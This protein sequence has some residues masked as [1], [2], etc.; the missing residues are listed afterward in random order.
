MMNVKA[1]GM[2]IATVAAYAMAGLV[3]LP[4]SLQAGDVFS[5]AKSWHRGFVDA[6]GD[7]VLDI[8][9]GKMEFPESLLIADTANAAHV[10]CSSA[11]GGTTWPTQIYNGHTSVVLRTE[12]VV[13][14][15]TKT[16]QSET[17]AYF[18]QDVDFSTSKYYAGAVNFTSPFAVDLTKECTF[19]IRYKWS[20]ESPAGADMQN[21][22]LCAGD[23]A[24]YGFLVS[25]MSNGCYN[26]YSAS[27]YGKT[28]NGATDVRVKPNEWTDFAVTVKNRKMT[29]YSYQ[30]SSD[31]IAILEVNGSS[32]APTGS[33][34]SRVVLGCSYADGGCGYGYNSTAQRIRAFRGSIQ[35]F[36]SWS[37]ALS[38]DEVRQVFAWP[39]TDLVRLGTANDSAQEFEGGVAPTTVNFNVAAKDAGLPQV[40][41]VT[42]TS[43]SAA[44]L[45]NVSVNGAAVG[46][47]SV[48]PGTTATL[49]VKKNLTVAGA[50]TLTLMRTPADPVTIDAIALGGSLQIGN[51]DGSLDEFAPET[52]GGKVFSDVKS[53][54]RGAIPWHGDNYPLRPDVGMNSSQPDF[55]ESLVGDKTSNMHAAAF[56]SPLEGADRSFGSTG[57]SGTHSGILVRTENVVYP[58]ARRTESAK[59]LYFPQ[60]S[61]AQSNGNYTYWTAGLHLNTNNVPFIPK[62]DQVNDSCTFFLRFR[63]DG[64]MPIPGQPAYFMGVGDTLGLT[65]GA[66]IGITE[67]GHYYFYSYRPNLNKTWNGTG[68]IVV[69]PNKWTDFAITLSN[70]KVTIYSYQEGSSSIAVMSATAAGASPSSC[71]ASKN[72]F[73]IGHGR[74]GLV[75]GTWTKNEARAYGFRGSIHSFAAWDRALGEDE[76]RQVFAWPGDSTL[77]NFGV[78]NDSNAEFGDTDQR[79]TAGMTVNNYSNGNDFWFS[80]RAVFTDAHSAQQ[81]NLR[82]LS[83]ANAD[84]SYILCMM[85]TADSDDSSFSLTINGSSV[86]TFTVTHGAMAYL[87]IPRGFLRETTGTDQNT[88]KLTRT[89]SGA[90]VKLDAFLVRRASSGDY[91]ATDLDQSDCAFGRYELVNGSEV[92]QP[93]SIHVDVPDAIAGNADYSVRVVV[94]FKASEAQTLTLAANGAAVAT[95]NAA[96]SDEIQKFKADVSAA[97]L[98]A[99]DNVLTLSNAAAQAGGST[100]LGVD[101]FRV[102]TIYHFGATLII[103]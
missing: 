28:W 86:G 41:R 83:A 59:A 78:V 11:S 54:H 65:Y 14:P 97:A 88:F 70:R 9:S 25:V 89:T 22:F 87:P 93:T 53:L 98:H 17:V 63:W 3:V 85:T 44:G 33:P 75:G 18:P 57:V 42:T 62:F 90:T 77:L 79:E 23:S 20:G 80:E 30:E 69:V 49:F 24:N 81:L 26:A 103:K 52:Y 92:R 38:A 43:T 21:Y 96:A 95:F 5:D 68:D 55:P 74:S 82:N 32:G 8:G 40:L 46:S 56:Q 71:D 35:S 1:I 47:L 76:I 39:G 73:V 7:G 101:C 29:I 102:V 48:S 67:A 60:D 91:Y 94:R 36:A 19:F 4:V 2:K 66:Y 45:F 72:S 61:E 31:G 51:A 64:T 37:R 6:N 100:W 13:N 27:V 58:Y 84:A 34:T 15:Y 50:N 16:R 99:G 12:N 10:I